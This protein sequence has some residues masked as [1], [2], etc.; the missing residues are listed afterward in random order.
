DIYVC[1]TELRRPHREARPGDENIA[2]ALRDIEE[3]RA[4]AYARV[5]EALRSERFRT[6][7]IDVVEWVETGPW[8]TDDDELR[9]ELRTRP[10]AELAKKELRRLRKTIK[11]R[12]ATLRHKSVREG[13][14]LRIRAKR[15]RYGTEFFAGTFDGHTSEKRR[16]DS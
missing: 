13:H 2:A 10:I 16:S 14:K 11:K 9:K 6:V 8:S 3:K 5:A 1:V 12:G 4:A 15:L 7:V